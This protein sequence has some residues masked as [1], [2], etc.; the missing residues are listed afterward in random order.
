MHSV[1]MMCIVQTGSVY[2]FYERSRGVEAEEGLMHL[3][4]QIFSS[5]SVNYV[6]RRRRPRPD[7]A[8]AHTVVVLRFFDMNSGSFPRIADYT[9]NKK[10]KKHSYDLTLR[11]AHLKYYRK[12]CA[13]LLFKCTEQTRSISDSVCAWVCMKHIIQTIIYRIISRTKRFNPMP[14]GVKQR[15]ITDICNFANL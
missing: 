12:C 1:Y 15:E 10:K 5:A 14:P 6:S 11:G 9:K 8:H 13:R 3:C 4:S 2:I 7:C